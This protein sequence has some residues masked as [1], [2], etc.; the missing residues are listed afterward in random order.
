MPQQLD[1]DSIDFRGIVRPG[2]YVCWGQAA[3]E[4]LGLSRRLM[5]Q[6]REIGP[7]SAFIG[8]SLSNTPSP[9]YADVVRFESFC[10][11]GTN[12]RLVGAGQLDILPLNYTA[13][14]PALVDRVDVLLLQLAEHPTA[15]TL[16]LST[17]CDYLHDLARCARV[18]VAE[19][20]A[21]APMTDALIDPADVD[22]I[23]RS[24]RALPELPPSPPLAVAD[25]IAA[26]VAELIDDRVSPCNSA[27]ALFRMRLPPACGTAV[28]SA[29]I[30][31][32]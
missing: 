19:I 31:G 30:P 7:F 14:T 13:M 16:S 21:R 25:R 23:V 2:S 5:A 3:A 18:V 15:G 12:R 29:F 17:N 1:L 32:C 20:N 10:G 22:V 27:S 26:H 9:K 8:I 28:I 24:E 11:T 6:R 4:P